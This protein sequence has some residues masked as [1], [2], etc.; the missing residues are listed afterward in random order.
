MNAIREHVQ[1]SRSCAAA[2]CSR[3]ACSRSTASAS[4]SRRRAS[5]ATSCTRSWRSSRARS[6]ACSTCSAA[7]ALQQLSIFALGIMPYVVGQHH[8]D[9]DERGRAARSTSC[10]RKASRASARS[11]STRATARSSSSRGPEHRHRAVPRG[12]QRQR[13]RQ[14]GDVVIEPGWSFRLM[15][16][17]SL[18]TGTAFIM[19][20]GEQITERGLGN[21]ISLII[22]AGIVS[23]L[24]DAVFNYRRSGQGRPDPAARPAD[25]AGIIVVVTRGRSCSSSARSAGSR[26]STPSAWSAG[27]CTAARARTCR[28]RSTAPA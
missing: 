22:F 19:W 17:I 16:I 12:P 1:D 5:T 25:R 7:G 20:L 28:S 23:G 21:G 4:S 14:F 10:A 13:G 18:T 2:S 3:S 27:R 11:T 15:T 26:S 6:S 8:P 9:A 24:P